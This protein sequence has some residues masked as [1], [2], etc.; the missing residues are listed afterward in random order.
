VF[1]KGMMPKRDEKVIPVFSP[2]EIDS[3]LRACTGSP[4][5]AARDKAIVAVLLD[6]GIRANELSTLTLSRVSFTTTAAH[7][8]VLGKGRKQRELGLGQRARL[9]LHRYVH[10]FRP[11]SDSDAVF[12]TIN[13]RQ[14]TK[15]GL[16]TMLIKLRDRTGL[17]FHIHPHKF[18]HTYAYLYMKNEAGDVLRLSR[19]LGHCSVVVTEQ[20]LKS[21]TSRD[22]NDGAS[23]LDSISARR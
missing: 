15:D 10:Q 20:Y 12:L 13:R 3:L 6:T 16:T 1:K 4:I 14:L 21:F 8:I 2:L 22:A 23:V 19:L 17:N 5:L 7:I 11:N 9:A 18:R